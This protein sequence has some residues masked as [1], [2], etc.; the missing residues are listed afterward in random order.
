MTRRCIIPLALAPLLS[1]GHQAS[2][3]AHAPA[4]LSGK[5][6]TEVEPIGE[7]R[8]AAG[9]SIAVPAYSSISISDRAE[10][11][12]LAVTLSIRNP[13]RAHPIVVTAVGYFGQDGQL[14]RDYLK[15][16]LRI[17]PMAAAGFFVRESDRTA[18]VLAS[19][20]VEWVAEH[21]VA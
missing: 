7:S 14:V 3:E 20:L 5:G 13:D 19:F 9:Q 6:A 12:D 10:P 1:C 2:P 17:A 15:K 18:G 4:I 11:F 8:V 21:P 16:P